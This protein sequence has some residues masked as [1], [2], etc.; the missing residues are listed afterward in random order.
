L[1]LEDKS[2][3]RTDNVVKLE[4]RKSLDSL[5]KNASNVTDTKEQILAQLYICD[6]IEKSLTLLG[7]KNLLG[8]AEFRS[9]WE[10]LLHIGTFDANKLVAAADKLNI[11][12]EDFGYWAYVAPGDDRK[13]LANEY[14]SF[15]KAAIQL[16][17][18]ELQYQL[19][20]PR[21]QNSK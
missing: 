11:P 6:E 17:R 8:V 9:L 3:P 16:A 12:F 7:K 2:M 18:E 20:D 14:R 10:S 4:P 5:V 1:K 13:L 15:L 21:L 19:Q